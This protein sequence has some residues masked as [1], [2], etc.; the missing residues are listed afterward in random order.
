MKTAY[1]FNDGKTTG[2]EKG[3]FKP[4]TAATGINWII[5]ARRAP[6][7]VSKTDKIRIFEPNVNQK[8]DAWKLDYRK[9]HDLWIPT[10]KLAG[11]WVNTGA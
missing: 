8:A 11:V 10:N 2:Q 6:I 5:I 3:G 9:F 7:A 4:D 1:V